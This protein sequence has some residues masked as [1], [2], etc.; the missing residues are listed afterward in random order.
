M[1]QSATAIQLGVIFA[2]HNG[3]YCISNSW[4]SLPTFDWAVIGMCLIL[5]KRGDPNCLRLSQAATDLCFH[6]IVRSRDDPG[7]ATKFEQVQLF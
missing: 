3:G 7:G 2:N 1:K 5:N 4:E 6:I